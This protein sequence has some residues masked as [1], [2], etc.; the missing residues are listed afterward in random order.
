M[1]WFWRTEQTLPE[2]VEAVHAKRFGARL[3]SA[4]RMPRMRPRLV[5]LVVGLALMAF[6]TPLSPVRAGSSGV[7]RGQ[8]LDADGDP[9]VGVDVYVSVP[10][11]PTL[12]A[13]TNERGHYRISGVRTGRVLVTIRAAHHQPYEERAIVTSPG[14]ARVDTRM[15]PYVVYG[16]RVVD[17]RGEPIA[18]VRVRPVIYTRENAPGAYYMRSD[19]G[20]AVTTDH[21]GRFVVDLAAE[22]RY[23][24]RFL[25]PHFQP[26]EQTSIPRDIAHSVRD[27]RVTLRDAA[28]I[29]GSVVDTS[30]EPISGAEVAGTWT[31]WWP[32]G[33]L[34]YENHVRLDGNRLSHWIRTD[35]DGRFLLGRFASDRATIYAR[36]PGS[37]IRRIVIDGLKRGQERSG[38]EVKL[39]QGSHSI[40]GVVTDGSG[41][42]IDQAVIE[43]VT[44]LERVSTHS[45]RNGAFQLTGIHLDGPVRVRVFAMDFCDLETA[46]IDV[47]SGGGIVV[48]MQ[49][50]PV[51]TGKVTDAS[52]ALIQSG[53][54]VR[55]RYSGTWHVSRS[56]SMSDLSYSS[57]GAGGI[58]VTIPANRATRLQFIADGYET[59]ETKPFEARPG[60]RLQGGTVRL[61]AR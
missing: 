3:V 23:V 1:H 54:Q 25:H 41:L 37:I 36:A 24:V 28:W 26:S 46:P 42:P 6:I 45:A 18:G 35:A 34:E 17:S 48:K 11:R 33:V 13:K 5:A 47:N 31:Y 15:V 22:T 51:W 16:G 39:E 4:M 32:Y 52:G 43:L 57:Q 9:A 8:V 29:S 30:G 49:P 61:R 53:F 55:V 59:T 58:D 20:A 19:P 14:G 50:S 56:W 2:L 10:A 21:D 7:V 38:L 44:D 27:A 12:R 40:G 60:Q